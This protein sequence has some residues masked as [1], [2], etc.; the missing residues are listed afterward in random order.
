MKVIWIACKCLVINGMQVLVTYQFA[1]R[2]QELN[3]DPSKAKKPHHRPKDAEEFARK[4][5]HGF[6]TVI[7][8]DDDAKSD[9]K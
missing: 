1:N 7:A 9:S 2:F 3:A 8:G 5:L 6:Y 4:Y